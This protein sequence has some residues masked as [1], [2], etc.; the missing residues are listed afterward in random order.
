MQNIFEYVCLYLHKQSCKYARILN[1]PNPVHSI[2]SLYK[3][4]SSYWDKP[5]QNIVKHLSWS[6]S[7]KRIMLS[8]G[9][10]PEFSVHGKFSGAKTFQ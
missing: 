3:L 5:I 1:V 6:V 2:R 10:Q 4:L 7:Q 9:M 8:A